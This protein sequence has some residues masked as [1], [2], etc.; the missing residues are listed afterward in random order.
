MIIKGLNR[1]ELVQNEMRRDA[2][3]FRFYKPSD[4]LAYPPHLAIG[5]TLEE[6][7]SKARFPCLVCFWEMLSCICSVEVERPLDRSRGQGSLADI[8]VERR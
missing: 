1:S 8:R 6:E 5:H 4:C 3:N 7:L 2:V